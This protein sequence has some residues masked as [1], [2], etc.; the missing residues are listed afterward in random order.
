MRVA[1]GQTIAASRARLAAINMHYL[2]V[3]GLLAIRMMMM[4]MATICVLMMLLFIM[5]VLVTM[6]LTWS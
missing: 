4:I 5:V 2:L 3:T 1:F 6:V